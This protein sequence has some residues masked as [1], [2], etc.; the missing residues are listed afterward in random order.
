MAEPIEA[1]TF[2]PLLN[3]TVKFRA[4]QDVVEAEVIEVTEKAHLQGDH[5]ERAP[6]SLVLRL[7]KGTNAP[8]AIYALE[9]ESF[10]TL[11]IFF[12]P[13]GPDE[14]GMLYHASFN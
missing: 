10:G 11:E 9:H 5:T 2:A 1:S 7:P 13:V 8:Q 4:G 6:F 14:K 3:Q 12:V